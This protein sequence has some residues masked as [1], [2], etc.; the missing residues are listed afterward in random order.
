MAQPDKKTNQAT[1]EDID[2]PRLTPQGRTDPDAKG[3]DSTDP[4][5][6]GAKKNHGS[7]AEG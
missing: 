3:Q 6:D 1:D 5:G 2:G 7:K 4:M